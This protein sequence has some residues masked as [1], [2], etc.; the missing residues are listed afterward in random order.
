[1]VTISTHRNT[2]HAATLT[3]TFLQLIADR[4]PVVSQVVATAEYLQVRAAGHE[5]L[6]QLV[7]LRRLLRLPP[8]LRE[9]DVTASH[10]HRARRK[11][12]L[13]PQLAHT[14]G[15]PQGWGV[16]TPCRPRHT[17]AVCH[18]RLATHAP[19]SPL[20]TS[21]SRVVDSSRG[22][23]P[24]GG[25][26]FASPTRPH[27]ST[28]TTSASR[29]R[30]IAHAR[31]HRPRPSRPSATPSCSPSEFTQSALRRWRGGGGKHTP[32]LGRTCNPSPSSVAAQSG[33][34]R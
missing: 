5:P 25:S 20:S 6:N 33:T 29:A 18:R 14:A 32:P 15:T 28:W 21:L 30:L 10:A 8:P 23:W 12:T 17:H 22:T 1:M 19:S 9:N 27:R 24:A 34:W 7:H 2:A 4:D 31:A 3:S 13:R 11:L 26:R 16:T